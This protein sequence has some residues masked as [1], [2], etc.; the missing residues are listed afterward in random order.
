MILLWI[1]IPDLH[2]IH[3][4]HQSYLPVMSECGSNPAGGFSFARFYG[5]SSLYV[6]L[7]GSRLAMNNVRGFPINQWVQVFIL[8][9]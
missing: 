4:R 5:I 7:N 2:F 9:R 8:T 6:S 3:R 1:L